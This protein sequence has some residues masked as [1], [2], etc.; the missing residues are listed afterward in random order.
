MKDTR[1]DTIRKIK[2]LEKIVKI[3]E[4]QLSDSKDYLKKLKMKERTYENTN[5]KN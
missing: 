1:E 2:A 4:E 5:S 3:Q